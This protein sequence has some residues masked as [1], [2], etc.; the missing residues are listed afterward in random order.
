MSEVGPQ[1]KDIVT[2]DVTRFEPPTVSAECVG[3]LAL[4]IDGRPITDAHPI[5]NKPLTFALS[6][7]EKSGDLWR[8]LLGRPTID[9]ARR[10]DV[11]IGLP[12]GP[13]LAQTNVDLEVLSSWS[14][15]IWLGVLAGL[16]KIPEP[17]VPKT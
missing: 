9:E 14:L 15:D 5:R 10:I 7:T 11:G 8:L 17:V 3:K 6:P 2:F 13:V 16:L 12:D 1:L 4:F